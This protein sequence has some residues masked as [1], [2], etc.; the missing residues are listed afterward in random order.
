MD[1]YRKKLLARIEQTPDL[2]LKKA[3]LF[4]GKS[5]AYLHKH[6][7]AGS[8]KKLDGDDRRKLAMLLK[9]REE[10]LLQE[11]ETL[12]DFKTIAVYDASDSEFTKIPVYDVYASAG[13]GCL[14]DNEHILY[15]L[16]F[17]TRWLKDISSS[18]IHKLAV[19]RV[20]GDSMERTLS[21]DDTV[22]VDMTQTYPRSDGI[23]V[24]LYDEVL[25]VKRVQIDPV[26]RLACIISDNPLYKP[27][28][29]LVPEDIKIAGRVLWLGRRV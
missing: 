18:P 8:P 16:S 14:V 26:R 25:M 12:D 7:H 9:V 19:I 21:H 2:D 3:S 23:Y 20:D 4:L 11:G 27:I 29:N 15:Y 17:R 22:L 5:P 10:D 24:V 1:D 6:I 13:N 28:E